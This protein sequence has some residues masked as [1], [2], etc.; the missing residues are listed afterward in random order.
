M[1]GI[2]K[3]A[4]ALIIAAAL[5][6]IG[7]AAEILY[8]LC[9]RRRAGPTSSPDDSGEE[10]SDKN[11]LFVLCFKKHQPSRVEPAATPPAP[12]VE[13][14]TPSATAAAEEEY[15]LE[16]WRATCRLGGPSRALYTIK[17]EEDPDVERGFGFGSDKDEG[18]PDTPY[19]TPA[20]SPPRVGE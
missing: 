6:V 2:T 1:S 13:A 10:F 18:G 11:L 19:F 20:A 12:I 8:I 4:L 7:F 17:E 9:H 16:R 3:L 15:D 14:K 5:L